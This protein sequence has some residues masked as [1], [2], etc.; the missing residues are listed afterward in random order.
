MANIYLM[1]HGTWATK[2]ATDAYTKV[3]KGTSVVIYTPIGRFIS[4]SQTSAILLD[5]PNR[6]TP[7]HTFTEFKSCPNITLSHGLFL[8]EEQALTNSGKTYYHPGV[9]A[10]TKLSDILD[11]DAF[12]GNTIHWLAC[13]PRFNHLDTTQGGFNDDY[14]LGP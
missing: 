7:H 5:A 11:S 10:R 12:K 8:E 9:G 13:Q 1:G 4:S 6:L 2:G 3:P 14:L